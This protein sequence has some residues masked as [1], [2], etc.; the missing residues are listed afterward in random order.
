MCGD[1]RNRDNVICIV[2]SQQSTQRQ[3]VETQRE[4]VEDVDNT[5]EAFKS[6]QRGKPIM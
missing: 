6:V 4:S 1:L 3:S 2:K 5:P